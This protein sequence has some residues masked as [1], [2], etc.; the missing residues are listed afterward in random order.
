MFLPGLSPAKSKGLRGLR[1]ARIADWSVQLHAFGPSG[2][3]RPAFVGRLGICANNGAERTP[4]ELREPM[5][6]SFLGPRSS[7]ADCGL[8]ADW[9]TD[10]HW[11]DCGLHFGHLAM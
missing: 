4:R 6:R 10:E 9:S 1:S 11:A 2:P 5:L 8:R 7:R 3:S